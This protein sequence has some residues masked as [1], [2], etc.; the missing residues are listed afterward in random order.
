[1]LKG[2]KNIK[3]ENES[4]GCKTASI[5]C[6]IFYGA[7]QALDSGF[8]RPW[9]LLDICKAKKRVNYFHFVFCRPLFLILTSFLSFIGPF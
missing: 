2:E 1:M 4:I 6:Y 8:R 7:V 9:A 3:V 5:F